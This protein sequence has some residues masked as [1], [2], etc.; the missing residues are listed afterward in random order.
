MKFLF[1][2]GNGRSGTSMLQDLLCRHPKIAGGPEFTF[3]KP[4]LQLHRQMAKDKFLERN[5]GYYNRDVLDARFRSF[6]ETYFDAL[7]KEHPNA[8]YLSE[9]TPDNI[10]VMV[11][12]LTLFPEAR[13]LFVYRDGRDVVLSNRNVYQRAPEQLDPSH[14]TL[15]RLSKRWKET[16]DLRRKV[17]ASL[18][19]RILD[20]RYEDLVSQ[21]E[22]VLRS[23][24]SFLGLG[25]GIDPASGDPTA[26]T[27]HVDDVWYTQEQREQA[28]TTQR[29]GKWKTDLGWF[30]RI[31]L[32]ASMAHHLDLMGY[33]TPAWAK[34]FHR[35]FRKSE[36]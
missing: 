25:A 19:D 21:P 4:L 29:I 22:T 32:Q 13:F 35:T 16:I 5:K 18:N 27:I 10:D 36:D 31:T 20:V 34:T 7:A 9:K 8:S 1:I 33:E 11:D 15:A 23:I 30:E 24:E 17:P 3:T 6:Y 28:V 26:N 14:F 12:L 2:G